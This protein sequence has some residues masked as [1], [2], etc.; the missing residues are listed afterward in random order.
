MKKFLF[1]LL[2]LPTLVQAQTA[3]LWI[4]T[5]GGTCVRQS[6]ASSYSS[7]SACANIQAALTACSPGDTIRMKTGSYGTQNIS[8]TKTTPGC[9]VIAEANTSVSSLTTNGAW[10]ELQNINTGG[11]DISS[12]GTN[13]ITCRNCNV[14][15]SSAGAVWWAT[16][17]SGAGSTSFSNISWIGGRLTGTRTTNEAC[18]MCIYP[19]LDVVGGSQ[20]TASNLLIEGVTFDDH[21][22]LGAG[23][24]NHFEVIR[25]DGAINGITFRRNTF[26]N[27]NTSTSQI[28]FTTFRGSK[29][30]NVVFEN[31][32]FGADATAFFAIQGNFQGGSTCTNFTFNYNTSLMSFLPDAASFGCS[33]SF[34]NFVWVGNIIPRGECQG[35]TFR[36]NLGYGA[37]GSACTGT[38]NIVAASAGLGGTDGFYLQTG[39]PAIGTGGTGADCI[40]VDHDNNTR[41]SPCDIGAHQFA[42]NPSP[43]EAP[44]NFRLNIDIWTTIALLGLLGGLLWRALNA[45]DPSRGGRGR[46]PAFAVR[47]RQVAGRQ[48]RSVAS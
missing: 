30:Q 4:D 40:A 33:G 42:A 14:T 17:V 12:R 39:S 16:S 27:N 44:I 9:T 25:V 26:K 29:P 11:W 34:S 24:G 13:N 43:P 5:D 8:A 45:P 1:L 35:N 36:Y 3:N 19:S 41:T 37:S 31:N 22:D 10:Y 46:W 6:T 21:V 47:V 48:A 18:A 2:L 7:A 38:G 28:F 32:F 15:S 20:Y 23:S